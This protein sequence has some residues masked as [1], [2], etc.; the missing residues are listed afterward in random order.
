MF[1]YRVMTKKQ[2]IFIFPSLCE[3]HCIRSGFKTISVSILGQLIYYTCM[4][5]KV[6]IKVSN[7]SQVRQRKETNGPASLIPKARLIT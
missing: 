3:K 2:G 5:D 6:V 7:H 1:G 4:A